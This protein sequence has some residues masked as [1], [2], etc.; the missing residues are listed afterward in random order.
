MTSNHTGQSVFAKLAVN[1]FAEYIDN[2][3]PKN[4]I[5][6]HNYEQW[7][8]EF[9]FDV[10]RGVRYG[11]SFCNRFDITDNILFYEQDPE[12]ADEYIRKTYIA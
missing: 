6:Y 9:V 10:L 3:I 12:W 2:K 11:Q 7:Q 1:I 5:S 4:C 8:Q